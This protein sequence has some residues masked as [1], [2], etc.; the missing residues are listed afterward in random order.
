[1]RIVVRRMLSQY[2]LTWF[3]IHFS[4]AG[5]FMAGSIRWLRVSPLRARFD[6]VTYWTR[7]F[8]VFNNPV[9]G[10]QIRITAQNTV[11]FDPGDGATQFLVANVTK[12]S[13][14]ED[15]FEAVTVIYHTYDQVTALAFIGI[16][17]NPAMLDPSRA[18]HQSPHRAC[19]RR[20]R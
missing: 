4:T 15:W 14:E 20:P 10:Q 2:F 18:A 1:M 12:V 17:P 5:S 9:V 3:E 7:S 6:L 16:Y 19:A 13:L 8:S 11:Q